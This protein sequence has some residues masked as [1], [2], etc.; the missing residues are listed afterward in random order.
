VA[1]Q[2][3]EPGSLYSWVAQAI[4]VRRESPELGWGEWRI[5]DVGDPRV[6]AIETRWR[7]HQMITLHNLSAEPAKVHLPGDPGEPA[8]G[9][10]MRQVLGDTGPPYIPGQEITLGRYGFRW[11]RLLD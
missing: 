8:Q 3:H 4:R 11:L 9:E 7:D 5:L 6:L 2:R 1:D 10:S